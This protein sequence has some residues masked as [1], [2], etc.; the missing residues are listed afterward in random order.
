[1]VRREFDSRRFLYSSSKRKEQPMRGM[2]RS[3]LILAVVLA[4]A[5]CGKSK[6]TLKGKV[7]LNGEPLSYGQVSAHNE[8][9]ELLAQGTIME[10]EYELTYVPLGSVRLTVQTHQPGGIPLG[11]KA[12]GTSDG[13]PPSQA[14]VMAALKQLPEPMQKAIEKLKPVPLKY[15]TTKDSDLKTTVAAGENTYNSEMSGKGESPPPPPGPKGRPGGPPVPPVGP[16]R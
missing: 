5:G 1:V 8:K 16:P 14:T 4:L 2:F 6:G 9:D 15:T 10:G 3:L 12:A 7:T 13:R 11:V